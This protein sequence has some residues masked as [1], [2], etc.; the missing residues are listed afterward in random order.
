MNFWWVNQNK[1]HKEEYEGEFMWS[2][3]RNK[4]KNGAYNQ[5]YKK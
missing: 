5:F 3:Q 1:T 4:N 2:P